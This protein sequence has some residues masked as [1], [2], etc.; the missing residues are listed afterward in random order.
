MAVIP[1]SF[2]VDIGK[3]I[4][5]VPSIRWEGLDKVLANLNKQIK[6]IPGKTM[7]GMLQA[8]LLVKRESQKKVPVDTGNLKASAYVIAG[9]GKETG[10]VNTQPLFRDE[11][12]GKS[13]L[14]S[15]KASRMAQQHQS[16]INERKGVL[17]LTSQGFF[18]ARPFAEIGF[19]AFYAIY[20]HENL[21]AS[22][23]KAKIVRKRTVKK[24]KYGIVGGFVQIGQ[25]KFLEHALMENAGRIF[26]IIKNSA[27]L[28]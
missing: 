19:T 9:G 27:R 15:G 16:T 2:G 3:G 10:R 28:K 12:G 25:A 20:V 11:L 14:I 6:L 18:G 4:I 17:M 26:N 1:T 5:N 23:V 22:H 21:K 13:A 7:Q 8:G 24:K